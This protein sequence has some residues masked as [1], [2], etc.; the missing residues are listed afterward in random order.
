MTNKENISPL[1]WS[2]EPCAREGYFQVN[3]DMHAVCT[4]QFCYADE[5]EANAKFIVKA[6]NH[7]DRLV[8]MVGKLSGYVALELATEANQ[9]LKEIK[10]D[11]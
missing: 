3:S 2:L 8:E 7:H 6:V 9:L 1:P 10:D 5:Y 4:N 11:E